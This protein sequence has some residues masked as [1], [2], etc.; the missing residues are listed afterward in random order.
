MLVVYAWDLILVLWYCRDVRR[1]IL[2]V[3]RSIIYL[4]VCPLNVMS[5]VMQC[6]WLDS[7]CFLSCIDTNHEVSRHWMWR[8]RSVLYLKFG[9]SFCLL[10]LRW[11]DPLLMLHVY[12]ELQFVQHIEQ[13]EYP[14]SVLNVWTVADSLYWIWCSMFTVINL[15][16]SI[17]LS[18][19]GTNRIL[20]WNQN[21]QQRS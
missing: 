20:S 15:L 9:T 18:N 2:K 16:F 6:L 7:D 13:Q 3:N 8:E 12:N 5:M 17:F 4:W 19:S 14:F 11:G 10:L 1:R 21:V